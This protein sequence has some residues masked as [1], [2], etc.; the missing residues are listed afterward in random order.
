MI[1]LKWLLYLA[2]G[3]VGLVWLMALLGMVRSLIATSRKLGARPDVR[4]VGWV[5]FG[6]VA[7]TVNAVWLLFAWGWYKLRRKPFP[8]WPGP[9]LPPRRGQPGS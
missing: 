2:G 6:S 9:P 5:L 7:T 3:L 8:P 1:F 4:D